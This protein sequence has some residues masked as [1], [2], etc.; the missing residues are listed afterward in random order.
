MTALA[1][2]RTR[3]GR[4]VWAVERGEGFRAL[5]SGAS[6]GDLLSGDVVAFREAVEGPVEEQAEGTPL[7]PVDPDTEVWAA[8]V[9]YEVSREAREAES[10]EADVYRKV[11]DA[12]RPEL[13]FKSTGWRTVG[14]DQH[15]G[16]REDS[17]WD[18]P[19]PELAL[20]VAASGEIAG[21]TICNDVSSRSIEGANPLYLPQ[22]KSYFGSCALGPAIVPA[23]EVDDPY[24]LT[25]HI[26]IQRGS[27]VLFEAETS[28]GSLH[29][30]LDEL[31]EYLFRGDVY[32]R[33]VI[34][35]TGTSLVPE[36]HVTLE[37]GDDVA[38]DITGIGVLHNP[39]R[40]GIAERR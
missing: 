35:S 6:L 40:R 24:G 11:Y 20:V 33:G 10:A 34:L 2:L 12:E 23:W 16:V 13:F 36:E 26:V 1:R 15:I 21:Y 4:S 7:A 39:V 25:I 32:P 27:E 37:D 19:E 29:R 38:I 3:E 17:S 30:R 18:V 22:A 14:P 31:V 8:G 28:T 5:S 9:T